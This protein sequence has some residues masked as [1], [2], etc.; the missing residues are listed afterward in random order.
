MYGYWVRDEL[1]FQVGYHRQSG[2]PYRRISLRLDTG[3]GAV[4]P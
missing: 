2:G 4:L 3:A 1:H